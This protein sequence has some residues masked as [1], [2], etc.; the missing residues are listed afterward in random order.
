VGR[1]GATVCIWDL[2]PTYPPELRNM[3]PGGSYRY[4][5]PRITEHGAGNQRNYS[6]N[7]VKEGNSRNMTAR[8]GVPTP[9]E[10][11]NMTAR[12]GV[13]TSSELRNGGTTTYHRVSRQR[14]NATQRAAAGAHG[15]IKAYFLLY[16]TCTRVQIVSLNPYSYTGKMTPSIQV[17]EVMRE[18]MGI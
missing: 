5:P 13:P 8:G 16:T 17:Y 4:L 3:V 18:R 2:L 11:R 14:N 1:Y 9:P 15:A 12:G 6:G 10:S 7:Q